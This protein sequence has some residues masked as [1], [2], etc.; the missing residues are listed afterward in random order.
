[1]VNYRGIFIT[2]APGQCLHLA[3]PKLGSKAQLMRKAMVFYRK[4]FP[5]YSGYFLHAFSHIAMFSAH[6]FVLLLRPG[7]IDIER[8]YRLLKVCYEPATST[9][10]LGGFFFFFFAAAT[11]ST[12]E[13]NKAG[14]ACH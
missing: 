5:M 6:L 12:N 1:M 14:S 11:I 7:T 2:L 10:F 8:K 13:T 4:K 9:T 3:Q